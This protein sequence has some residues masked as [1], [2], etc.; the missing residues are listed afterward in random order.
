MQ[1]VYM[2]TPQTPTPTLSSNPPPSV[3]IEFDTYSAK[4]FSPG[5]PRSIPAEM[6]V[7]PFWLKDKVWR[8][9]KPSKAPSSMV[10]LTWR[11][12]QHRQAASTT[13][14]T[15]TDDTKPRGTSKQKAGWR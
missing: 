4:V 10:T 9:F 14:S 3:L 2:N 6:R 12:A 13:V 15:Q 5:I 11:H 1:D 8:A 7:S